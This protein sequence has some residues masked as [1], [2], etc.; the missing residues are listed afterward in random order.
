MICGVGHR[1]DLDLALLWLWH[2]LAVAAPIRPLA[3]EPPY[4]MGAA[5]QKAKKRPKNKQNKK[6]ETGSSCH[7][8]VE[9]NP[10]RN[11]EVAGSIPGLAQWVKDQALP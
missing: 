5:L 8:T 10:T 1:H 4:A 9:T 2:R 3:P 7:A 11:H 6:T